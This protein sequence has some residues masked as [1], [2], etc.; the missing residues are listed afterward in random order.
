MAAIVPDPYRLTALVR[1]GYVM[2]G[3]LLK[4]FF[5]ATLRYL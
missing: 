1:V 5:V 2:V 3:G 4:L